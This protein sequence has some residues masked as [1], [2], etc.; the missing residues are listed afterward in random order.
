MNILRQPIKINIGTIKMIRYT[1]IFLLSFSLILLIVSCS[2]LNPVN[3]FFGIEMP[4]EEYHN[5]K[6]RAYTEET[7]ISY[8]SNNNMNPNFYAWAEVESK[9]LRIMINN[10][11]DETINMNR[12]EDQY[13][14]RLTDGSDVLLPLDPIKLHRY[15]V[16]INPGESVEIFLQLPQAFWTN[17]EKIIPGN[18]DEQNLRQYDEK[19][20]INFDKSGIAFI[21]VELKAGRIIYLKLVPQSSRRN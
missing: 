18:R 19:S 1:K 10:A 13:I 9:N 5:F 17:V 20:P 21:K 7:G 6:I 2:S 14:L 11:T 8:Y 12:N 3:D 4:E 16:Y 15:P